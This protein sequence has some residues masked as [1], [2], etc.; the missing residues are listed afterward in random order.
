[1]SNTF[2]VYVSTKTEPENMTVARDIAIDS[3]RNNHGKG[4]SGI[5]M[6]IGAHFLQVLEGH[7]SV[8]DELLDKIVKDD[9]HRDLRV[10]YRGKMEDRI[11]GRWSMGCVTPASGDAGGE[12]CFDDIAAEIRAHCEDG[13]GS[14]ERLKDLLIQIPKRLAAREVAI[15]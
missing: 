6:G 15:S 13:R 3:S 12:H 1:M 8:L 9:R 4:I 7:S 11:F 2:I 10:L 14:P 5:L